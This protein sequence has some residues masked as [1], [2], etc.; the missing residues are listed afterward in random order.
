MSTDVILALHLIG[1]MIGAGGGF[2]SMITMR[3]AAKVSPEHANTLRALGPAFA[4]FSTYGL[5]LMLLTGPALVA[6]KYNGFA[7]MPPLFWAKML[8]VATLTIAAIT[9]ELTYAQIKGGNMKAAA[10]L[11]MIGPIA[12]LSSILATI[13]AVLAFH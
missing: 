4:R 6:L 2:G 1:L 8:F 3:A 5:V 7:S 12:G 13:F 11:P 10:R 9:V